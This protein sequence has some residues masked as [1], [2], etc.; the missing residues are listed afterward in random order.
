MPWEIVKT[1]NPNIVY[2][3]QV[4]QALNRFEEHITVTLDGNEK[5]IY[6]GALL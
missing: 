5:L 2:V 6:E 3:S 4:P 1:I